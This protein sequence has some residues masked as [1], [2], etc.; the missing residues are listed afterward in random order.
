MDRQIRR[1]RGVILTSEGWQKF[2]QAKLDRE[3]QEKLGS[4]YTLE[5]ISHHAGL[6]PNTVAKVLDR[7]EAVDKKTLIHLFEAFN[8]E[9]NV[10]DYSKPDP[11]WTKFQHLKTPKRIDWGEAVD[12]S[13]FYGRTAELIQLEQWLVKKHC[14]VVALLGMG[15]IGKTSLA[16]KL[17]HQVKKQF[18]YVIWRSLY[19]APPLLEFLANLIQ[20]FSDSPISDTDLPN[21]VNARILQ[22]IDY[23]RNNRCLIVLDNVE[24]IMKS[25]TIAGRYQEGYEDYG[26]LIRRL[27]ETHHQSCLVLTSREKPKE[28]AC[29][30]GETLPVHSLKLNGLEAIEGQKIFTVKGLV[31]SESELRAIVERY[32][33]NALALRIVATTIQDVFDGNIS[34]FLKQ[35]KAVFGDIQDLLDQQFSRLSDIECEVMYWL[36]I[37]RE[38]IS[39]TDLQEDIILPIPPQKL[40]EAVES[41]TRRS[42]IEKS[43]SLFTLQPVV[44]EYVTNQF[45]EQVCQEI[46]TQNLELLRN[47]ALMKAQAKDYIREAQVRCIL[48]PVINGLLITLKIQRAIEEKLTQI[49]VRLRKTSQRELEYTA[50]NIINLFCQ[51]GTDLRGYDFSCL[52]V[53]QADLRRVQLQDVNFCHAD[54][55]K[56]V[57]AETFGGVSS[58]AFSPDG[59]LLAMGDSNGEIQLRQVSNGKQLLSLKEHTNWVTS[60]TFNHDGSTLASAS[61]DHMVKLWDISTGQC[62]QTLY[63]HEHEVWSVTFSPD[64]H[65]LASGS[66]DQTVRLWCVSTG[67]CQRILQGHTNWVISVAFCPDGKMLA[68]GSDDNT[69]RL[70]DAST[71]EC[72][73]VFQ[74]HGDGVRAIALNSQG[75]MLASGSDD[76]TIRLWDV[77]TGECNRILQGHSNGVWSVTF[78]PQ[79]NTLASGSHDQTVRLWD[80]DTGECLKIFQGHTDCVFSVTLN[81]KGDIL[82]S[83]SRDQTVRLWNV[84]TGKCLRT[85]RG[86]TSQVLSCSFSPDGTTLTSGGRDQMVRL[87]DVSTGQALKIFQGHTNWV[88]SVAFSPKGNT[89]VSCGGDKTVRLWDVSTG[90][91]LKILH[92]HSAAVWSVAFSPDGQKLASCSNDQTIKLW[93]AHTGQALTTLYGHG[94]VVWSIAFSP[95]EITLASGSWDQTIKL[96][97]ASTGKCLRTLEG[98]TSW[99]WSVAFSPDGNTL[100]ST[101]PDKTLRLWNPSTGECKRILQIDTGWLQLVAFRSDSQMLATSTQDYTI[102]LWDINTYKCL[103]T[104]SGH[105]GWIWSITFSPDNQTLASTSEDETMRLWD[106]QTGDCLKILKAEKL[107]ERMNITGITGLTEATMTTLRSLGS[108]N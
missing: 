53:W 45:V 100:V 81:P 12:V 65:T 102:K 47:Y 99:I 55:A 67:E 14:R 82:A 18:E 63:G 3:F 17:T 22:L 95:Q 33:G 62:L 23:L 30:E 87:W 9:L 51:M 5:E 1:N 46:V 85:L 8:L 60:V 34:E 105:T 13:V 40:L 43:A 78:S 50:G 39:L 93:D 10:C 59:K 31:G 75:T 98:H 76:N 42:L 90:Q 66:D 4:K 73:R 71:G 32:A 84:N 77:S 68:S 52:T 58:V 27:G 37:N 6:T 106:I 61:S 70:W 38:P 49:L 108:L 44:M 94:A 26:M 69:I 20:F 104:L 101:S 24:S 91:T 57:F 103:R 86:Y 83:G 74:G 54:L 56:S 89:L 16:T 72:K 107:Y 28:I 41:L 25:G 96:W 19:N 92:G 80:I 21:S 97:D 15:G 64:G 36:A 7:Q 11:D 2:Q 79:D 48:Q 35:E 88:N 29:L